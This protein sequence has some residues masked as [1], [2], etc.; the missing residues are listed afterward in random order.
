M[1]NLESRVILAREEFDKDM[2]YYRQLYS[3]RLSLLASIEANEGLLEG[4]FYL[5]AVD[6][7]KSIE[8][9][10]RRLINKYEDILSDYKGDSSALYH[11]IYRKVI[12]EQCS[13]C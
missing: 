9:A 2:E 7:N 8:I 3:Q 5:V 10:E 13:S 11:D 1:T 4:L 12:N 6:F